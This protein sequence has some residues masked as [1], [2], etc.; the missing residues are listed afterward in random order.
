M[1]VILMESTREHET[2][3]KPTAVLADISMPSQYGKDIMEQS[4]LE[5][6][7]PHA[8]RI[9]PQEQTTEATFNLMQSLETS[10]LIT[11]EQET[12][13]HSEEPSTLQNAAI[14]TSGAL[15]V[16]N[17]L[18]AQHMELLQDLEER[19]QP[20]QQA[21][22]KVGEITLPESEEVTSLDTLTDYVTPAVNKS[23]LSK[24][25]LVENTNTLDT[26]TA[27]TSEATYEIMESNLLQLTA[28]TPKLSDATKNLRCQKKQMF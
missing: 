12:T 8:E 17:K 16:A 20:Q 2:E 11:L 27:I 5:T 23:T 26:T 24:I 10:S 14:A 18:D 7:Q 21:Q 28:I 1:E 25:E 13:M 4:T 9:L 3:C 15:Q 22:F 19:T 6:L